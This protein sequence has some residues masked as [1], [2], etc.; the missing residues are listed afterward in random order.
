V[1]GGDGLPDAWRDRTVT[2]GAALALLAVGFLLGSFWLEWRHTRL[3][4]APGGD[5]VA[6]TPATVA[7]DWRS[8]VSVEVLNGLG[9]P[10]AARRAAGM[11]REMGFDVVYFGNADRFDHDSTLVLRR[12]EDSVAARRLA[13]SLG[14]ARVTAR[15]DPDL[16]VDGTVILGPGWRELLEARRAA[17]D[18]GLLE[19]VREK[20]GM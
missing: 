11:L 2:A 17:E 7:E 4:E 12:S 19:S 8:R 1:I 14:V 6:S 9:E 10:G 20:L 13:D 3:G 16:Y 5:R 18:A 15:P